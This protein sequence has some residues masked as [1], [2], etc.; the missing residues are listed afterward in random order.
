[1]IS[2]GVI[3]RQ[4]MIWCDE[5][6]VVRFVKTR[7]GEIKC[8][9]PTALKTGQAQWLD[10]FEQ[11]YGSRECSW[12]TESHFGTMFGFAAS[13]IPFI[14][15][16]PVPRSVYAA[17][18]I[19]QAVCSVGPQQYNTFANNVFVSRSQQRPIVSTEMARVLGMD[20][21]PIGTNVIV[22]I[23]P[24]DGYNQEDAVVLNRASVERGLFACDNYHTVSA[25]EEFHDQWLT[26]FVLPPKNIRNKFSNYCLLDC[27]SGIVKLGANVRVG[28][29]LVAQ[30]STRGDIS[31]DTSIVATQVDV[32]TVY[33]IVETEKA[34]FR[35]VKIV[36]CIDTPV[37]VG[38]KFASRYGQKGICGKI[39][40]S[41]EL[42]Y[43][44]D[45]T[46][47]DL[48]MNPLAFPSRMTIPTLL[49]ALIGRGLIFEQKTL[50]TSVFD[51]PPDRDLIHQTRLKLESFGQD[52]SGC[53]KMR[54]PYSGELMVPIFCGP[55][56]Y[57][58]LAHFASHKCYA[59]SKGK[60]CKHTRQPTDGRSR[61]G[62]LRFGEMERDA[63]IGLSMPHVLE[64]RLFYCS[65]AFWIH[66]CQTCFQVALNEN[67][68]L[69]GETSRIKKVKCSF[70]SN[71]IFAHFRALGCLVNM[72]V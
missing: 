34:G 42:P 28:D 39:V 54:H 56:Y 23:C 40:N 58:R 4:I 16:Q 24:V 41:W 65:D 67:T 13:T 47:P 38:D 49:E 30:V 46:V 59:R 60:M 44:E 8:D 72:K 20:R 9:W 69:C 12:E 35:S 64:D 36:I 33:R 62:G 15:Y 5:G 17:S 48:F 2:I 11:E 29:V 14:N 3:G 53:V 26:N 51:D 1:M 66:V 19:K 45:G 50:Q 71:L 18:M 70:T 21:F 57:S 31:R 37:I 32:G 25:E 68:C 6:R 43:R 7:P 27:K 22:A 55:M 10:A 63:V 61:L 52:P